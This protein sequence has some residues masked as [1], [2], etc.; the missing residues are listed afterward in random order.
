ME[1]R[2]IVWLL[3]WS[4]AACGG[5]EPNDAAPAGT[6]AS[7]ES[8]GEV[9][10][11]RHFDL[12]RHDGYTVVRTFGE[13]VSFQTTTDAETVEDVI[14]LVPRGHRPRSLPEEFADAYMVEVPART[15]A[16]NNDDLLALVSE[17]G[18]RDRL[19]AV[20][21]LTTYDD[22]VRAAVE[23][24]EIGQLGY[25]WHLPP[26][27][28]VLLTRSPDVTVLGMDA[29]DNVP[30]LGRS[31]DLGLA[32]VPAFVWAERDVLA[33]A[34][35]I[36]FF[37]ALLGLDDE[38]REWFDE[39]E[40][41]YQTLVERASAVVDTPTVMWGY[42][43]G[44]DRWF[45]M[46]NNLEARILADAAARNPFED[47]DGPVR[48]DGSE[49]SSEALLVSGA[50]AGHWVIGDIHQNQLPPDAFMSEFRAWREGALYHNYE[51]SK[52]DVNAYDWYEGGVVRP[53]VILADLIHLLHPDLLPDHTPQYMGRFDPE[54]AR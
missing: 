2:G 4:V 19:V 10:H 53:D 54:E 40:S 34:E 15:I 18:A 26:D 13:V 36:K 33:R 30:A 39:L 3:A 17:L 8:S 20:G 52:W 6:G 27:M 45:M 47:F 50:D 35:W 32:A 37:G 23:R 24:D 28:E 22:S 16:V 46:A 49:F 25:S 44:D 7:V 41:R 1:R 31:R 38:A 43:A 9:R 29:P 48:Y 5:S 14:V 21:G 51:R 42:H 12:S 11:A